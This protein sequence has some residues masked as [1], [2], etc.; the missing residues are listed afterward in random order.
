M[1]AR[2]KSEGMSERHQLCGSDEW[3]AVVRDS[4]LPWAIGDA[5]L[6][7]DVLE[8]A[9]FAA[10]EVKTNPFGWAALARKL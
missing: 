2:G 8:A 7:D 5:A 4:I 6:G 1:F 10:V 9:G 3:R